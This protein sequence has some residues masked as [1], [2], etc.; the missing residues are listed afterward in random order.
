MVEVTL[1]GCGGGM[2]TPTRYLSATLLTYNG[3]KI[4]MDCG[5]GTQVSM[6][7]IKAGFKTLD[8][9][10][11]T[12]LHGDH[13]NGLPGLLATMGNSGRVAPVFI[14]GPTG[15]RDVVAAIKVLVR[16]LPF[17]IQIIEH[18]TEPY[19]FGEIAITTLELDHSL[20][21]LGYAFEIKRRPQFIVA[22][23]IANGVPQPLWRKL[24][25]EMC[26]VQWE[27]KH[28]LPEM[29]LGEP[30]P[31]IRLCLITDTRPTAAM[32][33]FIRGCDLLICEGTYGDARD[34]DKALKYKHMTF[35]EAATLA[36]KGAVKQL[37]LT[38]FSVSMSDP[39]AYLHQAKAIFEN[40][41]LGYDHY[42]ITLNY[43]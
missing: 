20:S 22:K 14:M 42:T 24:Q 21:C 19:S 17:E 12:H 5:E 29:V 2:P 39:E 34:L 25:K 32:I 28:Y 31:G 30:R 15:I 41:E 26:P 36:Q 33:P 40:T 1:L 11:I 38:H 7:A 35:A 9:I 3:R 23:A 16:Q 10:C 27:G 13:I 8:M 4:L 37:L 6:K 43:S 18:P